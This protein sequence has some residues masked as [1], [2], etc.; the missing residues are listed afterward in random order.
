[1]TIL[2]F[3]SLKMKIEKSVWTRV[4]FEGRT[5]V[6]I[7]HGHAT[8][9]ST[10]YLAMNDGSCFPLPHVGRKGKR[11]RRYGGESIIAHENT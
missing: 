11:E 6:A 7:H 10:D 8:L 9:A 3:L 5:S 1:M 4:D 2:L